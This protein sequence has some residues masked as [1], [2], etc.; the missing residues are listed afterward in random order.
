[1]TARQSCEMKWSSRDEAELDFR[2]EESVSFE[3][4]EPE[5]DT[6]PELDEAPS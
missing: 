3:K 6:I 2:P 1:M 5:S 4:S